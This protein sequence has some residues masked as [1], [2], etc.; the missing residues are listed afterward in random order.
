V[1]TT[2]G[3]DIYKALVVNSS[4]GSGTVYVKIPAI[5]GPNEAVQ[6]SKMNMNK[7]SAGWGV[8]S[9]GTRVLVVVEDQEMTNVYLLNPP[10]APIT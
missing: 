4:Q 8:P 9:E 7:S 2:R 5:L 6:I 1:S 3:M 10:A